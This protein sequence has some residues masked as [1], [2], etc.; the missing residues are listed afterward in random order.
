MADAVFKVGEAVG[1][2]WSLFKQRA[3]F[4][5]GVAAIYLGVQILL[6]MIGGLFGSGSLLGLLWSLASFAVTTWVTLGF[7]SMVL[8]AVDGGKPAIEEL[9]MPRPVFWRYLGAS[10]L[11]TIAVGIGLFLL[12]IPGIYLIVRFGF[13]PFVMIDR[14]ASLTDSF[15]GASAIS[16]GQRWNILFFGLAVLLIVVA[17]ALALFV[18]LLVALPVTGLA[19]A[20]VYRKLAG[21]VRPESITIRPVGGAGF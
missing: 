14:D 15:T 4:W 13:W 21:A 17:G 16:E 19:S 11:Y 7:V 20:T 5:I 9:W 10:L 2:G 8:A 6:E 18:G 3:S 12:V 1:A